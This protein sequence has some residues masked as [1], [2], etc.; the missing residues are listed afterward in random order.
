MKNCRPSLIDYMAPHHA[1]LWRLLVF[2]SLS[3]I[4]QADFVA[5]YAT[6]PSVPPSLPFT[7]AITNQQ[8]ATISSGAPPAAGTP[9][10]STFSGRVNFLGT[11]YT[12]Q[13]NRGPVAHVLG[14][15][16]PN[17]RYSL[18]GTTI[19]GGGYAN[20]WTMFELGGAQSFSNA[21]SANC[22]TTREVPSLGSN[23]VALNTGANNTAG[24]GDIFDW[25]Q[26]QPSSDGTIV[27]YSGHYTGPVPG[28]TS[29]GPNGYQLAFLRVEEFGTQPGPVL[30]LQQPSSQTAA[31]GAP[32]TFAVQ[33]YAFGA[34]IAY[35]WHH[36]GQPIPGA[37]QSS[38]RIPIVSSNHAGWYSVQVSSSN[39]VRT[40]VEAELLVIPAEPSFTLHP[41]SQYGIV[42]SNL[43]LRAS[44]VGATPLRYQWQ[45]NEADIPAAS[46]ATLVIASARSADAG[47][48]R[49]LVT[50]AFGM[51]V[52]SN[53]LVQ[54]TTVGDALNCTNLNWTL[55][56]NSP[57][58]FP[59]AAISHDGEIA[60]QSGTFS[61]T[62]QSS[63]L[64]T[65]VEGPC[66]LSFWWR[67][68]GSNPEAVTQFAS[69]GTT[70]ALL[71]GGT[72]WRYEQFYFGSNSHS[73]EW[74]VFNNTAAVAAAAWLD[75]VTFRAGPQ[76]PE[77]PA[78]PVDRSVI[79]GATTT[80]SIEARGH[81]PLRYQWRFNGTDLA[82]ATSAALTLDQVQPE[83]AG[84]YTVVVTNDYGETSVD[85]DLTV[86]A[87]APVFLPFRNTVLAVADGDAWLHA[88]V[89]GSTPMHLQW[90]RGAVEI[91]GATNAIL[92]L[93]GVTTNDVGFYS[94]T[95]S[96]A[97]GHSVGPEMQLKLTEVRQVIHISADGLGGTYLAH[98]LKTDPARYPAFR[99]MREEGATTFNARC[100][101]FISFT[102]PNHLSMLTGR[103]SLR[104]PGQLETVHHGYVDDVSFAGETVH[105]RGNPVVPYKASVFDVVHDRGMRTA[106]Y[107]GKSSL[108]VCAFSYDSVNGAPDQLEPDNGRDKIDVEHIGRDGDFV[109]AQVAADLATGAPPQYTFV[110]FSAMDTAGHVHGWGSLAWFDALE[111]LDALVGRIIAAVETNA[112]SVA[113]GTVVL[114][115]ADHGG[116]DSGWGGFQHHDSTRPLNYTIP[117]LVWGPGFPAA[118][119][120]HS[121]FVN[122]IDPG[123]NQV[124]YNA[125]W[126]P[127]R[128]GDS[129]NLALQCL[130]LPPIP[131]SSLL[132]MPVNSPPPLVVESAAGTV[133]LGWSRSAIGFALETATSLGAGAEWTPVVQGVQTNASTFSYRIEGPTD[134]RYFRLSSPP[135]RSKN[136]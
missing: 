108:A 91:A 103:P 120:L 117:L 92:M 29:D 5:F 97:L 1:V 121:R 47:V 28:G 81:P 61:R 73:L 134:M 74:T 14:R 106:I 94:V 107:T 86:T 27:I 83:Q 9:A 65:M 2:I 34:P 16:N 75:Q 132:P 133:Q 10:F 54:L 42:G 111:M 66:F 58:W 109:A 127:L 93:H 129:G 136:P 11:I 56:G 80:L 68:D 110:H 67:Q 82:G 124:D 7:V 104:S 33:A 52:S 79:A 131:G 71:T 116:G 62:G 123:T 38:Y 13:S 85:V 101:Y 26:V 8:F 25:E 84:V 122:R 119:D 55:D 113:E 105:S 46:N 3:S 114:L 112:A 72:D 20:R 22:L 87:S 53:A 37:A 43:T 21:H 31:V 49:V 35:Q 60:L 126:Q 115:T 64:R 95:A 98:A 125:P 6:S 40:S 50:N 12:V 4:A 90:R 102:V 89:I 18:K 36:N 51:A 76:P 128:N 88:K 63:R 118:S 99:R 44:A 77:I 48:Y 96:N 19:R 100:D 45:F 39:S 17:R 30:I 41:S 130:R 15:L 32:V 23:Q 135:R 78:P 24:T 59:Q 70:L 57:L 69:D